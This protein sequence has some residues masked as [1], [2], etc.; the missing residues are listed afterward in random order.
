MGEAENIAR[1]NESQG[2]V[3]MR[4]GKMLCAPK[5]ETESKV[6]EFIVNGFESLV[7]GNKATAFRLEHCAGQ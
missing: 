6:A 4:W 2:A 3:M 5:A 1:V 7:V